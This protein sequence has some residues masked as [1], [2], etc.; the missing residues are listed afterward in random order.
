MEIEDYT[1]IRGRR[2]RIRA[3]VALC[4][5]LA[6]LGLG[7]FILV[8]YNIYSTSDYPKC[9]FGNFKT[10]IYIIS[11][12]DIFCGLVI[13]SAS[14]FQLVAIREWSVGH[15]N[16]RDFWL[17]YYKE[18]NSTWGL[19]L[20]ILQISVIGFATS[21]E[22]RVFT[23]SECDPYVYYAILINVDVLYNIVLI[24]VVGYLSG[25]LIFG[26][27]YGLWSVIR[28]I[29]ALCCMDVSLGNFGFG[30]FA[31]GRT[32]IG[33][34]SPMPNQIVIPMIAEQTNNAQTQQQIIPKIIPKVI[35]FTEPDEC[36]IC[37]DPQCCGV[38]FSHCTHWVCEVCW[39]RLMLD[40]QPCPLCR[41][42]II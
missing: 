28:E 13:G 21:N 2:F 40:Q 15:L 23:P 1:P 5:S 39:S 26:V 8:R 35:Q 42:Q 3:A 38:K 9:Q 22:F 27:L 32:R 19:I 10:N 25:Y 36:V 30:L 4:Y 31:R 7:V 33:V 37:I 24:G 18:Y 16:S 29:G 14:I 12:A 34:I 17:N 41:A 11:V 6:L 20:F